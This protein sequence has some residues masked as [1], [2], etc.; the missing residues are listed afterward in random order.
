MARAKFRSKIDLINGYE[1]VRI[2]MANISKTVFLSIIGTYMSNIMQIEDCNAPATFQR[3]MTSIIWDVIGRFVYIYLD[4]IFIYSDM[5]EE[6]EE[7]LHIIFKRLRSNLLFLKWKKCELYTET[8]NCLRHKIDSQDIHPDQYK[9][10]YIC[11]WQI[12]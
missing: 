2:C 11:E 12:P 1:Q 6:Y 5:I 3:L 9:I 7:H 4:G 10:D 8:V